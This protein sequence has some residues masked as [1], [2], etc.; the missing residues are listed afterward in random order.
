MRE[1]SVSSP[2]PSEIAQSK[3]SSATHVALGQQLQKKGQPRDGIPEFRK[4]VQ[5][6]PNN[7]EAQFWLA[8][9]LYMI[10]AKRVG[11]TTSSYP[12]PP[13]VLDEA[14]LHMQK[15]VAL[16]P[17]DPSWHSAL[18]TYLSNRGR[19]VEALAEYRQ[20]MHLLPPLSPADIKPSADGSI[21]GKIQ[22]W[23][24]A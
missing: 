22:P 3:V 8:N 7:A 18:G 16:R 5:I 10:K 4:A 20:S 13:A 24:D 2:A 1:T 15:A 14:I 11:H 17:K 19:H 12:A 9:A 6:D 23:Y 21:S